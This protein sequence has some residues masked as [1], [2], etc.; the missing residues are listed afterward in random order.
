MGSTYTS[1]Y[2]AD[3]MR[4]FDHNSSNPGKREESRDSVWAGSKP[5]QHLEKDCFLAKKQENNL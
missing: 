3:R 2:H 5:A 4:A 1:I